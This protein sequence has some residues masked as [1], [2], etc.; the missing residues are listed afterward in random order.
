MTLSAWLT[1]KTFNIGKRLLSGVLFYPECTTAR[2]LRINSVEGWRSETGIMGNLN[3]AFFA[4]LLFGFWERWHSELVLF[5]LLVLGWR[6]CILSWRS[7][8]NTI[9]FKTELWV[10]V[11]VP[12][13]IWKRWRDNLNWDR[14]YYRMN[15]RKRHCLRLLYQIVHKNPINNILFKFFFHAATTQVQ[16]KI[17][18]PLL[19]YCILKLDFHISLAAFTVK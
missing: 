14:H 5:L 19:L 7:L 18:F 11:P 13:I 16:T 1:S 9:I 15:S 12:N 2:N 10:V 6:W 17:V 8:K 4:L 3:G